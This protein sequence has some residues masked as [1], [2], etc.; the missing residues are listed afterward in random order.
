MKP[1]LCFSQARLALADASTDVLLEEKKAL[2]GQVVNLL[3][4]HEQLSSD[5]P[6]HM[7]Q[8]RFIPHCVFC[9][10]I[11]GEHKHHSVLLSYGHQLNFQNIR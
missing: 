11:L 1:A 8:V 5:L 10:A 4:H 7:Q 6:L 3:N 2:E 9:L